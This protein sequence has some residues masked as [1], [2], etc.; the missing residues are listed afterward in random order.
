MVPNEPFIV[1]VQSIYVSQIFLKSLHVSQISPK[2]LYVSQISPKSL[3][4]SQISLY[5]F[6]NRNQLKTKGE[7]SKE[8]AYS[9]IHYSFS[10]PLFLVQNL[11]I[12]NLLS[13]FGTPKGT[14][15]S[16]NFGP[17]HPDNLAPDIC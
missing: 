16:H 5:I 9:G 6:L 8:Q 3:Y 15:Q 13:H 11:L 12:R 1:I 7:N 14:E 4:V 17:S 10:E 2:S